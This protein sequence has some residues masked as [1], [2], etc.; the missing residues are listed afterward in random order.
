MRRV[1]SPQWDGIPLCPDGSRFHDVSGRNLDLHSW[2]TG[3]S[4]LFRSGCC[5]KYRLICC[6]V[7]ATMFLHATSRPVS[8]RNY[9]QGQLFV[10][11]I[12]SGQELPGFVPRT[13]TYCHLM[14]AL[15]YLVI[16]YPDIPIHESTVSR[17]VLPHAS[18]QTSF[19]QSLRYQALRLLAL[20]SQYYGDEMNAVLVEF[21]SGPLRS[22]PSVIYAG[23]ILFD[24]ITIN[25]LLHIDPQYQA[26]YQA[27]LQNAVLDDADVARPATHWG[28]VALPYFAM[29]HAFG[30]PENY[31]K[32]G[33]P[34]VKF[35]LPSASMPRTV[36]EIAQTVR[37]ISLWVEQGKKIGP[38]GLQNLSPWESGLAPWEVDTFLK[39]M[40]LVGI[41]P[42]PLFPLA[43]CD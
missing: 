34:P 21:L 38:N 12:F 25:P 23:Q 42:I 26:L 11:A 5:R 6:V 28:A 40:A 18:G 29:Q 3:G 16:S 37:E 24:M 32:A 30:G 2:Y 1:R 36:R 41:Q 22:T 14:N 8:S 10:D 9:D 31:S 13:D 39:R 20:M 19:P 33:L 27:F 7:V 17:Y 15:G 35:P 43:Q 4:T